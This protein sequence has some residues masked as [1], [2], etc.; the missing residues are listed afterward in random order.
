MAY[1]VPGSLG[2]IEFAKETVF[3]TLPVAGWRYLG[4]MRSLDTTDDPGAETIPSD[5]SRIFSDVI[6]TARDCKFSGEMSIFRDQPPY[7]WTDLLEL[8]SGSVAGSSSKMQDDIPS[9]SAVVKIAADQY[10]LAKGCKISELTLSAEGAGKQVRASVSVLARE[11]TEQQV[12]RSALGVSG[13]APSSPVTPPVTYTAYPA[14]TI[15][16]LAAIP[17]MSF[18]LK[19]SNNLTAKEGFAGNDALLAGAGIVPGAVDI[20][21]EL[22]VMSVSKIWDTLKRG[23]TKGFTSSITLDGWK[24]DLKNAYLPGDDQPSRS[25]EVYDETIKIKA[26]DLSYIKVV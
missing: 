14:S 16:G 17:S 10:M 13:T 21:F 2:I 6:F 7:T 26:A 19:I 24:I 9:F 22:K 8:A 12:S 5:G 4:C 15:P 18:S 3:G 25:H 1:K 20:D 23:G 11:I